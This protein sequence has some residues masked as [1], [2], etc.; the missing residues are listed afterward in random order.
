MIIL[1]GK[2][3]VNY[4]GKIKLL[5]F[6]LRTSSEEKLTLYRFAVNAINQAWV[7]IVKE[8]LDC[9]QKKNVISLDEANKV[10]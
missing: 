2:S 3:I 8:C 6:F 5:L 7:M 4:F 10:S 1:L 9:L